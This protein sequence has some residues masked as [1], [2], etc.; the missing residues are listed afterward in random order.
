M[1]GILTGWPGGERKGSN[2]ELG[3]TPAVRKQAVACGAV[4]EVW[5][6][7]GV[8]ERAWCCGLKSALRGDRGYVSVLWTGMRFCGSVSDE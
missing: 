4:D 1:R 3:R 6:D 8:G 2:G 5:G 7:G